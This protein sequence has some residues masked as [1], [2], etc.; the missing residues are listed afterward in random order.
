MKKFSKLLVIALMFIL[1]LSLTACKKEADYKDYIGY[2]FSGKDPW[3]NEL[4]VTVR[5]IENDKITWTFTDVVGEGESS[6]TL[7]NELSTEFKDGETSFN[8]KGSADDNNTYDYTGT[9]T[10]KDGKLLVKFEKGSVT[11]NSTEG[12]SSAYQAEALEESARTITL[13]KVVDNS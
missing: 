3:G 1:T 11:T 12:G 10:L 8:A 7:Y 6:L 4:A 13:T 2:Q 5:T 9:L